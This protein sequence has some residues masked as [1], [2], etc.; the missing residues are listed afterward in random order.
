MSSVNRYQVAYPFQSTRPR[1]ARQRHKE[2]GQRENCFNPRAHGGRDGLCLRR[3]AARA[4][5]SIHAPTGGATLPGG[6]DDFTVSVS[7]HAPTGGATGS[8]SSRLAWQ[9]FQSTRPRGARPLHPSPDILTG[10]V[11]IHAPTGGAT[12]YVVATWRYDRS[13][14][15]RAHGG[16][17]SRV[18]RVTLR[19]TSFNPRAHGGRDSFMASVTMRSCMFQ[20]TRPRG[21][22]LG[23]AVVAVSVAV[24]SI[25]APTG[26]ATAPVGIVR[27]GSQ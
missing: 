25:H 27:F 23:V 17:D 12:Y 3:A 8:A 1:G 5:V 11:S 26:G 2:N 15:P 6:L 18:L 7:I 16:R 24:V 9:Q 4:R 19:S 20:S 13:F 14:N 22:R 21:A 10:W